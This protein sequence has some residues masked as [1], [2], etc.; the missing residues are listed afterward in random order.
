MPHVFDRFVRG[1]PDALE[2]G[3]AGIG[4]ALARSV[5]GTLGVDVR[6]ETPKTEG[7]SFRS[8]ADRRTGRGV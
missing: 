1:D 3:H 2:A 4:L 8:F 6:A 5:A 7:W